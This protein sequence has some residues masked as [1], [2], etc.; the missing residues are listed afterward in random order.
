VLPLNRQQGVQEGSRG[1]FRVADDDTV[2]VTG[3]LAD[4]NGRGVIPGGLTKIAENGG[5]PADRKGEV[6]FAIAEVAA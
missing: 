4:A 2:Q 5:Q 3:L 1:Q 6:S